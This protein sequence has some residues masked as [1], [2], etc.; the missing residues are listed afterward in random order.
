VHIV[1]WLVTYW[2]V[3][4]H[5]FVLNEENLWEATDLKVSSFLLSTLRIKVANCLLHN[6]NTIVS[7]FI[8]LATEHNFSTHLELQWR[9]TVPT[10]TNKAHMAFPTSWCVVP[11]NLIQI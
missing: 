2:A 6:F 9:T 5:E 8:A 1:F 10:A 3:G 11:W 7:F 4:V